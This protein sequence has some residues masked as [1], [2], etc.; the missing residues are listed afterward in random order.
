MVRGRV[1][2]LSS[3]EGVGETIQALLNALAEGDAD[4][5]LSWIPSDWFDRYI[6]RFELQRFP[7][8]EEAMRALTQQ[9]GE[10]GWK[11]LQA[12]VTQQAPE[13]VRDLPQWEVLKTIWH[14]YFHLEEGQVRW[15]KEP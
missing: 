10:D 13:A 3:W 11:L 6:H 12:Q 14:Q 7:K 15:R 4:W 8:G 2:R 9:V 5:V 1:R